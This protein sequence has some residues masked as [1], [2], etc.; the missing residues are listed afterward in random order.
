MFCPQTPPSSASW[1]SD[2]STLHPLNISRTNFSK[3]QQED[4]WLGPL[5]NSLMSNNDVSVLGG[6]SK[7]DQSWVISTVIISYH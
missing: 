2:L 6:L 7:K 3:K 1:P 5:I 4:K